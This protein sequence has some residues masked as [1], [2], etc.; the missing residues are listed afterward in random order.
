MERDEYLGSDVG[1]QIIGCAMRVHSGLGPGLP[2]KVYQACLVHE[3][4]NI[5]SK[6]ERQV[7]LPVRYRD[8]ILD[9]GYRIEV[10]VNGVIV[11]ELKVV[12]GLNDLHLS[13]L[14][15]YLKLGDYKLGY[16]MNFNVRHMTY[17]IKRVIN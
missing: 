16:L 10:L 5:S 12:D 9:C 15:S 8:V 17:G 7:S 6:A 2:E 13:Q 11:L 3:L 1:R 4:R 14:L